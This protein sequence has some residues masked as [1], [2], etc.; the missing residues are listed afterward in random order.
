L[1]GAAPPVSERAFARQR[2]SHDTDNRNLVWDYSVIVLG[3][4]RMFRTGRQNST[5]DSILVL[6]FWLKVTD[7]SQTGRFSRLQRDALDQISPDL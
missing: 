3:R 4:I 7:G 2:T 1:G 5:P 6:Y